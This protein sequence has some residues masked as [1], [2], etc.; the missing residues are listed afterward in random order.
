MNIVT[1]SEE[2]AEW[3]YDLAMSERYSDTIGGRIHWARRNKRP[4]LTLTA[5]AEQLGVRPS[6]LSGVEHNKVGLS[7][8]AFAASILT[9]PSELLPR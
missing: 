6:H 8:E 3:G 7:L 5:I 4:A 1:E 9:L 2:T